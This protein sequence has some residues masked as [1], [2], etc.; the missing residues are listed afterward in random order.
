MIYSNILLLERGIK[1]GEY[2]EVIA[3]NIRYYRKLAKLSQKELA[4]KLGIS[5]AAVSNW[6]KGT[7]SIDIDTLFEVCRILEV[8]I[9]DMAEVSPSNYNFYLTPH[10]IL[11]INAYRSA[12]EITK[13]NICSILKVDSKGGEK[14]DDTQE[15][16]M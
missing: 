10:E 9:S 15:S 1:M 7:N 2:K 11:L 4:D 13:D 8:S 3:R 16:E 14:I 6:E 12:N 5:S